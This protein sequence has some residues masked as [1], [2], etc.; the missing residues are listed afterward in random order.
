M[1]ILGFPPYYKKRKNSIGDLNDD[2]ANSDHWFLYGWPTSS[3]LDVNVVQHHLPFVLH[4]N[5][6]DCIHTVGVLIK[7]AVPAVV[8]QNDNE[9]NF[10]V[11]P[12]M[13]LWRHASV[14]KLLE[15]A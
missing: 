1:S 14:M 15:V 2:I 9:T 8:E 5:P 3:K 7:E 10:F 13:A 4:S 12:V 6:F 11:V